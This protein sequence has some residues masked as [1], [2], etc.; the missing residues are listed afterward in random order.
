MPTSTKDEAIARADTAIETAIATMLAADN[1]LDRVG[2]LRLLTQRML[3]KNVTNK[4]RV[5]TAQTT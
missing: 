1:A 3:K 2:A 4:T 5:R